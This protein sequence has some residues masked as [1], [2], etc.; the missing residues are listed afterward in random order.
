M[1]EPAVAA[2]AH[3]HTNT[4]DPSVRLCYMILWWGMQNIS[5]WWRSFSPQGLHCKKTIWFC[6]WLCDCHF[7]CRVLAGLEVDKLLPI[8]RANVPACGAGQRESRFSRRNVCFSPLNRFTFGCLWCFW[9]GCGV[10]TR[11]AQDKK[12]HA[13]E[14]SP[15]SQTKQRSSCYKRTQRQSL[16]RMPSLVYGQHYQLWPAV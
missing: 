3:T 16:F 10:E 15:A 8:V 4:M 11:D 5:C 12:R 13:Y 6:D 9:P 14:A 1:V 2:R 7:A